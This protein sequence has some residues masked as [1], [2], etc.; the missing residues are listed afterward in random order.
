MARRISRSTRR[1]RSTR[2][3]RRIRRT[4]STRRTR[5]VSRGGSTRRSRSKGCGSKPKRTRR[6]SRRSHRGGFVRQHSVQQF[7]TG[8]RKS[9][10]NKRLS[11]KKHGG[12]SGVTGGTGVKK[13]QFPWLRQPNPT[14]PKLNM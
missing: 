14:P 3:A 5:R 1:T 11:R 10:K 7:M 13:P 4:R 9:I 8:S 12:S 2:S 6:R